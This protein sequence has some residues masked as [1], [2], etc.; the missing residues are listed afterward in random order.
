MTRLTLKEI[1]EPYPKLAKKLSSASPEIQER[2]LSALSA[3]KHNQR[4]MSVFNIALGS[5]RQ[6][7]ITMSQ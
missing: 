4:H 7:H 3:T 2:V 1:K 5:S 6:D